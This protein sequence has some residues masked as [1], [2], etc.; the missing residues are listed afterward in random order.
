M[1]D[2]SS[3]ICNCE[4]EKMAPAVSTQF[5]PQN[6]VSLYFTLFLGNDTFFVKLICLTY[7][8]PSSH[9]LVFTPLHS[10]CNLESYR[11]TLREKAQDHLLYRE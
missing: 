4:C 1:F 3:F 8:D 9:I 7:P 10:D 11:K 6:F 2:V 5:M